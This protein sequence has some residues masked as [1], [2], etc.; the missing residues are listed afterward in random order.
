M[1]HT[2][3]EALDELRAQGAYGHITLGDTQGQPTAVLMDLGTFD[4]LCLQARTGVKQ[5]PAKAAQKRK[6]TRGERKAR[7]RERQRREEAA[8][9]GRV[10]R[11]RRG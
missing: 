8:K 3:Q 2:I 7:Q 5:A 11:G 6:P 4:A 1:I 10:A 9:R